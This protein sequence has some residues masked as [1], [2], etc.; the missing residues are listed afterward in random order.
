MIDCVVV[1]GGPAGLAA[2][3]A[4]SDRDVEHIV[5]E[6]ARVGQSWRAQR[7]DSLRLNNPGW[8]NPMLGPQPRDTHLTASE[9]VQRLESLAA[10]CPVREFAA[11]TRMRAGQDRWDLEIGGGV[12]RTCAVVI[13]TGGENQPRTPLLARSMPR[14]IAQFHAADYRKPGQLPDG[15][16]LIVGSAQSG[17]QIAEELCAAGRRVILSTSPVGRAP[18]RY[19]GVDTVEL[20]VRSGFFQ[21]RTLD[22]PDMSITKAPQPLLA[23]GGRSLSLQLLVRA[24]VTLT[25]RL[26]GVQND[27]VTFDDTARANVAMAD[28]FAARITAMLDQI[29]GPP[30]STRPDESDEAAGRIDDLIEPR[31]LNLRAAAVGS[32][33]WSTGYTGD[34][35][36]L[37][38]H[39]VDADGQPRHRN[40]AAV[41]A[42]GVRYIGLRW[43]TH[44]ASGNFLGIPADALTTADAIAAHL[45]VGRRVPS[46]REGHA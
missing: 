1:G 4:L 26:I 22:L 20:L 23:P 31:A 6:R 27:T 7:W 19:R 40:G 5:L 34:F 29:V 12:I 17:C 46:G 13:A 32:I 41:S 3:A 36:W 28:Q 10:R 14:W 18:A 37:P 2:S 15:A 42:P 33:I 11:V 45:A 16:V 9:V 30:D 38:A 39:L 35:S 43:L 24:G 21:Q 8:M 44:R 25:G